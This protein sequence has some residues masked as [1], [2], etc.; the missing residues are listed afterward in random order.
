M[1]LFAGEGVTIECGG[2]DDLLTAPMAPPIDPVPVDP[3]PGAAYATPA[4]VDGRLFF[5]QV[6]QLTCLN[7]LHPREISIMI[8]GRVNRDNY[9]GNFDKYRGVSIALRW[10]VAL[11]QASPASI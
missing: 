3:N 10:G 1:R 8:Y 5:N 9:D 11:A 4:D 2:G 6:E 7:Q